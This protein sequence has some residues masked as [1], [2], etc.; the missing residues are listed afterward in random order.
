MVRNACP[1]ACG[2]CQT[3]VEYLPS[4]GYNETNNDGIEDDDNEDNETLDD[5]KGND[6]T[7]QSEQE[8][9][10]TSP[11]SDG[12]DSLGVALG[13]SLGAAFGVS[14][15]IVSL[16][17]G[18]LRR[19]EWS[20][21]VISIDSLQK[22]DKPQTHRQRLQSLKRT[23]R[24]QEQEMGKEHTANAKVHYDIGMLMFDNNNKNSSLESFQNAIDILDIDTSETNPNV[25]TIHYMMAET[26]K[27]Q[28]R[29]TDASKSY[30][31]ALKIHEKIKKQS[32]NVSK[33]Y[34]KIGEMYQ[35]RGDSDEAL[36]YTR[37]ALHTEINVSGQDDIKTVLIH[38]RIGTLL[39][40]KNDIDRAY[41]SYRY[42]LEIL[43][44]NLEIENRSRRMYGEV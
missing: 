40:E 35:H 32:T 24:F 28:K 12:N 11:D 30:K 17:T 31:K 39:Q 10:E 22:E 8:E 6:D 3:Y 42:A 29:Y 44:E 36:K 33:L 1:V 13:I 26:Y 20:E 41:K 15:L 4:Y 19:K 37:A 14:A 27:K 18:V 2:F 25:A 21:G 23:L 7:V 34:F 38:D 5:E 9:K 16:F 43:I